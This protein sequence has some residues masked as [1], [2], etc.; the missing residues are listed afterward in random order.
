MQ[1]SGHSIF[2]DDI[3]QEVQG[4]VSYIGVYGP[5][6]NIATPFPAALPKFGITTFIRIQASDTDDIEA[7]KLLINAYFPGEKEDTPRYSIPIDA[8]TVQQGL[9]KMR[10]L[11]SVPSDEQDTERSL[12]LA[13]PVLMAN[14]VISQ[15]G[16]IRIRGI[17]G[18]RRFRLGA[19]RV[20]AA[21]PQGPPFQNPGHDP[22]R[23]G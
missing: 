3:R 13:I 11:A 15:P 5:E 17:M 6:M 16:L 19:L 18:V 1:V 12:Q 20:N 22:A 8:E 2:C 21:P 10:E 9:Q 7:S 23:N 4:T 14:V